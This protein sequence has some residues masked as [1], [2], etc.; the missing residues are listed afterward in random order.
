MGDYSTNLRTQ[1]LNAR[2]HTT[3]RR[4]EFRFDKNT[5]YQSNLRLINLGLKKAGAAG[6]Y[7]SG[8]GVLS[9]LQNVR[10]MDGSRELSSLRN[11][12][13]YLGFKNINATN[14]KVQNIHD[15]LHK[16]RASFQLS[17]VG[18]VESSHDSSNVIPQDTFDPKQNGYIDLRLVLPL[19][20]NLPALDTSVFKNLRIVI[21]YSNLSQF[22]SRDKSDVLT[23]E[24][25][26]L[27]CDEVV[28]EKKMKMLKDAM[29]GTVVWSEIEH[30]VFTVPQ[31]TQPTGG[32]G[33]PNELVQSFSAVVNGFDNKYVSRMLIVK[34]PNS[35]VYEYGG[36]AALGNGN[37][38]SRA[39]FKEKLNI[40]HKG[41]NVFNGD[42][43][44]NVAF[45]QMLLSET[46]GDVTVPPFGASTGIG[47]D[48]DSGQSIH[49]S[50]Q[51][52]VVNAGFTQKKSHRIGQYDYLGFQ[53][54]DVVRQ[55]Q[56]SYERTALKTN[57]TNLNN[58][59][60]L[61][62]HLYAEVRK[63]LTFTSGVY[64]VS[65]A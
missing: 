33:G 44:E 11:A 36:N 39:M 43:L 40:R 55:L 46:F 63:S 3:N 65:Y 56:F 54:E 23:I 25:P 59:L 13:A 27:V 45:R 35:K 41:S 50:G 21:E 1:Y 20:G 28:G 24:E 26:T 62:V 10:L 30:D 42:G 51:L 37:I 6:E 60:A 53:M 14:E 15:V 22:A 47:R 61:D 34:Q 38:Q 17:G 49:V 64:D 29:K 18:D 5:L 12:P 4:T 8:A 16:S 48:P 31:A 9:L 52:P 19:L 57:A 2:T 58:V 32:A 7:N